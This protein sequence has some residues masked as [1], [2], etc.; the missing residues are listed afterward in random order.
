MRPGFHSI[1][2]YLSIRDAAGA[3]EFYK[4]AF[5]AEEITK[6]VDPKGVIR[7]AEIKVG[8]SPIMLHEEVP[9]FPELKSVQAM[10]GS[11]LNLFCYVDDV[12]AFVARAISAGAREN[13][14]ITDQ[15][16]GRSGGVNDPFGLTWWVTTHRDSA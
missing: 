13:G 3:I 8:D 2:P 15:P 12:D 7:H 11:P 9:E 5:G 6:H 14:K 4:K 16:Y 10:G 1:T